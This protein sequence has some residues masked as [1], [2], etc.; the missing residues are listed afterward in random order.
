MFIL[1]RAH[2]RRVSARDQIRR[3]HDEVC[4]LS[5]SNVWSRQSLYN[6]PVAA[7]QYVELSSKRHYV[8]LIQSQSWVWFTSPSFCRT[9]VQSP[10]S[11]TDYLALSTSVI[12]G[13]AGA[14]DISTIVLN[15]IEQKELQWITVLV[16]SS[17][18]V[19]QMVTSA[20][21]GTYSL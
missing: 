21:V 20:C 6:S 9:F 13:S 16:S 7:G 11:D 5:D 4:R 19:A 18:N 15:V 1:P 10:K 12:N 8:C 14:V 3:T 17:L 2:L